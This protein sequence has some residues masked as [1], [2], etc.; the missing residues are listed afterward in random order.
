MKPI[1]KKV[2]EF[3]KLILNLEGSERSTFFKDLNS[4]V[5]L[6]CEITED[7]KRIPI[8]IGKGKSDRCLS[9]LADL[10][11]HSSIK[12]RKI[13]YLLNENKLGID[14]LAHGLNEKT[15]LAIESACIDLYRLDGN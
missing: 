15:A 8:Y 6:Y 11:D 14:I 7:K 12:T 3:K 10:D 4:Y 5:Y 1:T 9:H 13:R 2:I